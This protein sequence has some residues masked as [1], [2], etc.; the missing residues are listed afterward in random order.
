MLSR[1]DSGLCNQAGRPQFFYPEYGMLGSIATT[2][3]TEE[4]GVQLSQGRGMRIMSE[5]IDFL[6][7]IGIL[8]LVITALVRS[9]CLPEHKLLFCT[10]LAAL[11]PV[12]S[13]VSQLL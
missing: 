4:D 11:V 5:R 2:T 1:A 9:V 12:V 6:V 10:P 7:A 3:K 8:R 13:L